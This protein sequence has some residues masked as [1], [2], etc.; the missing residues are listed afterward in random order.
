MAKTGFPQ[1]SYA[2]GCI[3][4]FRYCPHPLKG[5]NKPGDRCSPLGDGEKQEWKMRQFV[6]YYDLP[7]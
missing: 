4:N 7:E 3:S 6:M 1:I 2:E 5:N